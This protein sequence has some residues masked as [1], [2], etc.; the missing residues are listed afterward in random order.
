MANEEQVI[1]IK[2]K[3]A[4]AA[5]HGGPW[6]VAYADFVTAMMALF[7]VLWLMNSSKPVEEAV[8]GYFRDPNGVASKKGT[9]MGGSGPNAPVQK[10]EDLAKLKDELM[11]T[12]EKMPGF[13]KVKN[14]IRMTVTPEGL[15]I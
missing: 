7:I 2:K 1:I 3:A 15:R 9:A 5:H 11:K 10:K 8:G 6:K 14:Q 4:H 13:D 12:L